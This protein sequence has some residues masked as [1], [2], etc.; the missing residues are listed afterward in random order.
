M[1]SSETKEK[2][3]GKYKENHHEQSLFEGMFI[4]N[5]KIKNFIHQL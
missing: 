5:A 3:Y 4:I 2:G 1:V